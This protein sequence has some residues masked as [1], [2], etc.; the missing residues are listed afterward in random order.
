MPRL[1]L[2]RLLML[3]LLALSSTVVA[4]DFPDRPVKVIVPFAAGGGSD[5]FV[6]VVQSVIESEN[7]LGQP[8]VVI[9]VPGGGGTI[10]SRRVLEETPDGYT[11]LNLHDGIISAFVAKT[12]EYGPEA[13]RPL[14]ATG[15]TASMLCVREDARWLDLTDLMD[16]AVQRPGKVRFGANLGALSYFDALR[17][18]KAVPGAAFRFVSTGGGAKRFADLIGDGI[19]ATAFNIAEFNQ[20]R[21][22]GV[23]A[24]AVFSEQRH[25]DFPDVPTARECGVNVVRDSMQ[26]WWAPPGTPDEV[27]EKLT[28]VL[29]DAMA[30]PALQQRLADLKMDPVFFTGRELEEHL[31]RQQIA[32]STVG[33]RPLLL[34][35]TPLLIMTVSILL[36]GGLLG[37]RLWEHKVRPA[38]GPIDPRVPSDS[39]LPVLRQN[40]ALLTLLLLV[41][42][43]LSFGFELAPFWLLAGV[44]VMTTGGLLLEWNR[45]NLIVMVILA[46]AAGPGSFTLFTKLLTIDLS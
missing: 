46:M 22:A 6:R 45:R 23:K 35:D 38:T 24:L 36:A 27:V 30:T 5:T 20:F 13:F 15:R 31:S 1:V 40:P 7:L 26:Y 29:R 28:S 41:A 17:V 39:T 21:A 42:F 9:N 14:A 10:G 2:S 19:D 3:V 11:I 25:P 43:C 4:D 44:F 32:M 12:V 18:E 33:A 16:E 37:G 8:L 34:P